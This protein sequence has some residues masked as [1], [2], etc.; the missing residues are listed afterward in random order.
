MS[1]L[2]AVRVKKMVKSKGKTAEL[3]NRLDNVKY[4]IGILLRASKKYFV[5]YWIISLLM[6][7]IPFVTLYLWKELLNSLVNV[8]SLRAEKAIEAIVITTIFYCVSMLV[9]KCMNTF[10]KV[11][12]YKYNDEIDYYID[13]ILI[14]T[15]IQAD[16]AFF[17]SSKLQDKLNHVAGLMGAVTKNIP[18]FLFEAIQ[19]VI[20]IIVSLIVISQISPVFP[21]IVMALSVPSVIGNKKI[22]KRDYEFDKK[23]IKMERRAGYYQGLFQGGTLFEMK[24]Y[25]LKDYFS[26][27]YVD[28]WT[29]LCRAKLRHSLINNLIYGISVILFAVLDV[30]IYILTISKLVIHEIGVGD[31]SYYISI[32]KDFRWRFVG[33]FSS[34]NDLLELTDEF[35]DI[36]DFLEQKP[37]VRKTGKR[38]VKNNPCI[39]FKKVSF[40]YPNSE[41][42]VLKDCSFS[43]KPGEVV[44]LV[45]LNG[46]GKST[47]IKLLCRFY[48]PTEGVIYVDGV[49]AREY[50]I[51]SLRTLF[52]ALF[53][54]YV[55][56]SLT[57]RE[58]IGLSDVSRIDE[59]AQLLEACRKSR[60]NDFIG[61]WEKGMDE[62]MTRQFDPEGKELSV[63][64]WQRVSLARAFFRNAPIILLDEPSAALD[65]VA[66]HEIFEE[67]AEISEGKSGVLIS[68]RLS[69]IT[70]CD[71]ILLLEDGKI[72]EQGSHEALM[73]MNGRYAYLFRLQASKYI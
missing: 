47:I 61:E 9:Q 31:V 53:Q 7:L 11:V 51:S 16:L 40:Q 43:I 37:V 18:R 69:S 15:T 65:P 55:R 27:L 50:D 23:Y 35:S 56:Y 12:A 36:R 21:L 63:G 13:N 73:K 38:T 60:V 34:V 3:R 39:E 42:Y 6:V 14:D 19:M 5:L 52:G 62:N 68:H 57:L 29:V 41:E 22:N 54:D 33:V 28:N 10:Q 48:D 59:D 26:K 46:A 20:W 45:G 8:Q 4:A 67:F 58:N 30:F 49:D 25:D 72:I 24:L 44:G 1:C 32:L 64:Q 2:T 66:E 71:K 17:D 70:L